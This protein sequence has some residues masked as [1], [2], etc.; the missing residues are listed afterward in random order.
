ALAQE[1]STLAATKERGAVRC[2]V[3]QELLGFG[4]LDPDSGEIVG[5]DVDICHAMAAAILGD[6]SAVELVPVTA[7]TRLEALSS[8]E[9]DVLSRNTTWTLTRDTDNGLDF[10]TTTFYDGQSIMVRANSGLNTWE[11]LDG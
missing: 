9:I 8:G 2:G 11:D 7:T 10:A 3:N 4:L 1:G 5:F 6:A